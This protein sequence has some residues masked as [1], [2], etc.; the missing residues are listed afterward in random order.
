VT[1]DVT[2]TKIQA[3]GLSRAAWR[4]GRQLKPEGL[5]R[6][7]ALGVVVDERGPVRHH[8][9]VHRVPVTAQ[10]PGHLGHGAAEAGHLLRRPPPSPVR[11][12]RLSG[13]DAGV[14][15]GERAHRAVP[16]RSRACARRAWPDGR[17]PAGRRARRWA[18]P[19][20]TPPRRTTGSRP[21]PCAARRTRRRSSPCPPRRARHGGQ[22]HQQLAHARRVGLHKGLSRTR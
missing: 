1:R 21:S 16:V 11:H 8:R 10:V 7:D 14:L 18:G 12:R 20:P 9:V 2:A 3:A 15:A 17:R 5:D 4:V 13:S 19:S 22:A 6:P